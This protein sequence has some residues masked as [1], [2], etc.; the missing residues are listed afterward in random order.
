MSVMLTGLGLK[1]KIT[2][3][4]FFMSQFQLLRL[5]AYKNKY[6]LM[7][8]NIVSKE[9]FI[10][11]ICGMEIDFQYL[12]FSI[13]FRS[14]IINNSLTKYSYARSLYDKIICR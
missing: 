10:V 6:L 14:D 13:C 2:Q 4:F 1:N 9:M 11:K 7:L 5:F 12:F 3:G 8:Q